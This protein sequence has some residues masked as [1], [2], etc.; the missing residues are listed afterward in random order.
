[1]KKE[2]IGDGAYVRVNE[3]DGL[4]LELTTEDD[5]RVTNEISL[6][7]RVWA[8]LKAYAEALEAE[9]EPVTHD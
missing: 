1:M 2:Y 9:K 5:I 4:T 6:E 3:I 8:E 7:P